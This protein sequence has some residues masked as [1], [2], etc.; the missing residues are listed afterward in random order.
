MLA[1]AAHILILQPG[2]Q[3]PVAIET[4]PTHLLLLAEAAGDALQQTSWNLLQSF[5]TDL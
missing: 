2:A 1:K 3:T 5:E 4:L